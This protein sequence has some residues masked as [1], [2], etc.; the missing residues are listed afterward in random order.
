MGLPPASSSGPRNRS[1][2]A[3]Q[4][5]A[6]SESQARPQCSRAPVGDRRQETCA[7]SASRGGGTP[8]NITPPYHKLS[9]GIEA[10]EAV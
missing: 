5:T 4:R 3:L 9:S 2:I 8:K 6:L 7:C 10:S 1:A